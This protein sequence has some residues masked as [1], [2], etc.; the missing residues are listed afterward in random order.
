[1]PWGFTEG[2][3]TVF[4][5]C[6]SGFALL[7]LCAGFTALGQPQTGMETPVD[8]V[9]PLAPVDERAMPPSYGPP[10]PYGYAPPPSMP[11][12][13]PPPGPPAPAHEGAGADTVDGH[14]REGAFLSSPGSLTFITHHSLLGAAGGFV[15]QG[16]GNG[17]RFDRGAREAMVIGSVLGA[18]IGFGGSTWWQFN[19][20]VGLPTAY[21]GIAHSLFGGMALTGLTNLF[22]NDLTLLAWM[23][24]IGAEAGAWLTAILGA[25]EFTFS[26]GIFTTSAA[27]WLTAYAALVLAMLG[28]GGVDLSGEAIANVL[29]LAPGIGAGAAALTMLGFRPTAAQALRADLFGVGAGGLTLLIAGLL[30]GF[31]SATPYLLSMLTSAVAITAVSI[32]WDASAERSAE[33]LPAASGEKRRYTGLW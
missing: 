15:T 6:S 28:N 31:D 20:W 17:F 3:G 14:L 32:F 12:R 5:R 33:W 18:A 23:G 21:F 10:Q 1:M 24:F 22:A 7:L 2:G 16:I 26:D 4:D 25:G 9:E 27:F 29:L 30:L 8:P 19:H 11:V 13:P